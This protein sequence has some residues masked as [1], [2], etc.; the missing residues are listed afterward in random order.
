MLINIQRELKF[1][2]EQDY[3]THTYI[4]IRVCIKCLYEPKVKTIYELQIQ[5]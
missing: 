4:Y 3:D 5:Y 1:Q 2:N